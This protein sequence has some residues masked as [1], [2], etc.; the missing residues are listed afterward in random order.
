MQRDV[1]SDIANWR[2]K[3]T[4]QLYNVATP[5]LD[6]HQFKEEELRSVGESSKVCSQIFMK[7]MYLARIG[8][9]TFYGQ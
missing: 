6:D 7:C 9:Q 4:Q 1:W 2:T 8:R 3:K 5:W